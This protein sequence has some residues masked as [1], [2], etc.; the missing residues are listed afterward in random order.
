[1]SFVC[2]AGPVRL[3]HSLV[4]I[5]QPQTDEERKNC[6]NHHHH[7][8]VTTRQKLGPGPSGRRCGEMNRFRFRLMNAIPRPRCRHAK[9]AIGHLVFMHISSVVCALNGPV[10]ERTV[11]AYGSV[12]YRLLLRRDWCGTWCSATHHCYQII[13]FIWC[14]VK[15]WQF[16]VMPTTHCRLRHP[17]R[18]IFVVE[19]EYCFLAVAA[20]VAAVV[21]Y[22]NQFLHRCTQTPY[23]ANVIYSITK[24][25]TPHTSRPQNANC[26]WE[27]ASS[28]YNEPTTLYYV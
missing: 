5:A 20:A 27:R 7:R 23:G 15:P 24:R 16:L 11:S 2:A 14:F 9:R 12:L 10:V 17:Q 18:H 4:A 26:I 21:W 25:R 1:M 8:R 13:H 28:A 6:N 3:M 22:R 19:R